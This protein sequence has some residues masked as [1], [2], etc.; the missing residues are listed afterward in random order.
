LENDSVVCFIPFNSHVSWK[1][2]GKVILFHNHSFPERWDWWFHSPRNKIYLFFLTRIHLFSILLILWCLSFNH[3]S[4]YHNENIRKQRGVFLSNTSHPWSSGTPNME[5]HQCWT[6]IRYPIHVSYFPPYV[7]RKYPIIPL[8]LKS[9]DELKLFTTIKVFY[10]RTKHI[11]IQCHSICEKVL[12]KLLEFV[13]SSDQLSHILSIFEFIIFSSFLQVWSIWLARTCLW[14]VFREKYSLSRTIYMLRD[15][16]SNSVIFL[17]S[18][19]LRIC[20]M[21]Q[22]IEWLEKPFHFTNLANWID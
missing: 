20:S 5:N 3:Y 6:L 10:E 7:P 19:E 16:S 11:S 12:T 8:L 21:C 2:C 18:Q 22:T 17:P 9:I 13:N 4:T 14:G 1:N 15:S